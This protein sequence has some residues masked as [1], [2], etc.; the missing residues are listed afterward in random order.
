MTDIHIKKDKELKNIGGHKPFG[1]DIDP[2]D[3]LCLTEDEERG[4]KAYYNG[5]P[6]KYM[7]YMNE[8][9][10]RLDRNKKGK[11]LDS[12]IFSGFGKGTLSKNMRNKNNG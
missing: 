5:Q 4:Q 12:K 11:D 2:N 10:L 8:I 6:M 1:L 3:K 9:G 7:D